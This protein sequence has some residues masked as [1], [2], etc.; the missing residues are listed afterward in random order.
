MPAGKPR[1]GSDVPFKARHSLPRRSNPTIFRI[2]TRQALR[3]STYLVFGRDGGIRT[4]GL[5]VPNQALYQT[6][7][8]LDKHIQF[9]LKNRFVVP[10][11]IERRGALLLVGADGS[12]CAIRLEIAGRRPSSPVENAAGGVLLGSRRLSHIS[13]K[14]FNLI[15]KTDLLPLCRPSA[16]ARSCSAAV[17]I[18]QSA[19][20]CKSFFRIGRP[21]RDEKERS[22]K[23]KGDARRFPRKNRGKAT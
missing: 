23:Q 5:L 17:I 21:V 16:G 20:Q 1:R 19:R 11:Q 14:I 18:A 2:K 9:D 13:K 15:G 4:H 22:G 10:L 12:F 7:P 3:W 8:H 6:E